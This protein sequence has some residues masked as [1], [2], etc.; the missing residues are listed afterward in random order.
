MSP[1]PRSASESANMKPTLC[2]VRTYFRP[3]LPSPT[4]RNRF[5]IGWRKET[6]TAALPAITRL[7]RPISSALRRRL[8]RPSQPR[9]RPQRLRRLPPRS[10]G[11]RSGVILGPGRRATWR[12]RRPEYC[13]SPK[14]ST[15]S[16]ADDVA[17]VNGLVPSAC[18]SHRFRCTRA[19]QQAARARAP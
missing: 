14:S 3:G 17:D 9:P 11:C 5:S 19:G 12:R 15:P 2:R 6:D 1:V 7:L 4:I 10:G 13:G 8:Q 16:G 18:R